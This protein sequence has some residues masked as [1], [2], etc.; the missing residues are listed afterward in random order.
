M[1][2]LFIVQDTRGRG[3]ETPNIESFYQHLKEFHRNGI[4]VHEEEGRY[5]IVNDNFRE[6]IKKMF[7]GR[8]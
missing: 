1:K 4:S 7:E 3:Y 5:F 2:K 8:K 6:K